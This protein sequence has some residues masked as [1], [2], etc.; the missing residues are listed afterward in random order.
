M[1]VPSNSGWR[2]RSWEEEMYRTG[3]WEAVLGYRDVTAT[4]YVRWILINDIV[5]YY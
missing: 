3:L 5:F 1:C 2:K 4:V